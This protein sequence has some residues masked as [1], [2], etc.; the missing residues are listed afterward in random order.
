[1]I[2]TGFVG[3][4]TEKLR[5]E[6]DAQMAS[7]TG[8]DEAQLRV[9][10][11]TDDGTLR[12][13]PPPTRGDRDIG[14]SV[15]DAY[16]SDPR[17]HPF[18]PTVDVRDKVVVLTGVAPNAEA[19]DAAVQDAGNTSGVVDVR[20]N[21][22]LMDAVAHRSDDEI[23]QEV[24]D[25]IVRDGRMRRL[26]LS[27]DVQD[28]RVYLRGTVHTEA[29]RL[30]AIALATSARGARNVEDSIVLVP[31]LGVTNPQPPSE[32]QPP[33]QQPPPAP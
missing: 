21:M 31:K 27:V 13:K 29:D 3:S 11:W 10:P 33:S 25:A 9:D 32:H 28:G 17:V 8:V 14:Q 19:R 30:H 26:H 6:H 5:A 7:P 2:L 24:V 16:V 4:D 22:K 15:L 20:D 1:V 18:V 12:A 23:R